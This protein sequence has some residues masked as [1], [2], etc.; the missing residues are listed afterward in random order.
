MCYDDGMLKML[1]ETG[2]SPPEGFPEDQNALPG[3]QHEPLTRPSARPDDVEI[4]RASPDAASTGFRTSGKERT[5]LYTIGSVA[6]G[7]LKG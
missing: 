7:G 2:A 4:F 1:A 6:L 5:E 3:A